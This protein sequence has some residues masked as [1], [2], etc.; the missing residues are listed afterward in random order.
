MVLS[1]I[2]R[3]ITFDITCTLYYIKT[4]RITLTF[5]PFITQCTILFLFLKCLIFLSNNDSLNMKL[6]MTF[7]LSSLIK[8]SF[9]SAF[10]III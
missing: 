3:N 1:K 7:R 9:K 10:A 2:C 5:L 4:N 6:I 8:T